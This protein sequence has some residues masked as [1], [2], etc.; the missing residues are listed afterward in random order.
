[1]RAPLTQE[2]FTPR[3]RADLHW[4][5]S[6]CSQQAA[7]SGFRLQDLTPSSVS[8]D[9]K[10]VVSEGPHRGQSHTAPRQAL[11]GHSCLAR[12]G[13]GGQ[14]CGCGVLQHGQPQAS[15]MIPPRMPQCYYFLVPDLEQ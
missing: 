10:E 8:V 4:P 2:P 11:P 12:D 6:C 13:F 7:E 5:R 3:P 1:M 14:S 9:I 15:H